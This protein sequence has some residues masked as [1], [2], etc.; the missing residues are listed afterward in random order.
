MKVVN[1]SR[2]DDATVLR[3]LAFAGRGVKTTHVTVTVKDTCH[4]M[5]GRANSD[6][7][8]RRLAS[9]HPR[10][11]KRKYKVALFVGPDWQFPRKGYLDYRLKTLPPIDLDTALECLVYLAA[12][13]LRHVHQFRR[14][15]PLSER[16]CERCAHRKL[17]LWREAEAAR[18][19]LRRLAGAAVPARAGSGAQQ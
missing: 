7:W 3:A 9:A 6:G 5:H 10:E 17:A 11:W 18:A 19:Q 2:F 8:V 1:A 14:R 4:M 15:K 16:D 13:E 12:H